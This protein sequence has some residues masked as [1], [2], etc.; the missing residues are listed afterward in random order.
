MN[1]PGI[2]KPYLDFGTIDT[3]DRNVPITWVIADGTDAEC[4][5]LHILCTSHIEKEEDLED[6]DYTKWV[7]EVFIPC[8]FAETEIGHIKGI[9]TVD[10][11]YYKTYFDA[12]KAEANEIGFDHPALCVDK[13]G[14]FGKEHWYYILETK[15]GGFDQ[16]PVVE[17]EEAA[18]AYFEQ[19]GKGSD[20]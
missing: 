11:D 10:L 14:P 20:K 19:N 4:N 6:L 18:K 16:V 1:E 3:D 17:I 12:D 7:E 9:D 5:E 2:V 15:D 8:I 13:T